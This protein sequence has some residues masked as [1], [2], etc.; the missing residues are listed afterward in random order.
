MEDD[1]FLC[2][3]KVTNYPVFGSYRFLQDGNGFVFQLNFLL[4]IKVLCTNI[5]LSEKNERYVG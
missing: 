3:W 4:S 5:K 2:K 1:Y